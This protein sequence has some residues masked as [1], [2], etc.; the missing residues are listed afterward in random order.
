MPIQASNVTHNNNGHFYRI[1]I[2]IAKEGAEV[3]DLTPYFKGRV[4]DDNFGLQI[5]WYY[6]GRLLDVTG[7]TPYIKGN[8]G[9]YSFDDQKNLQLAPDA[10]VVVSHGNPNDCQANGQATYYFPQQMFMTD[11]VFKGFIGLQDDNQNLTGVDIWFRVLPGVAKMGHACDVYVDVLDK[12]IADFKEKIRQQSIDF[13]AALQQELQKEKALIQQKLDAAD[14]AMDED[15]AALKKLAAAVGA[16]QVQIDAGNV[17]S[18]QEFDMKVSQLSFDQQNVGQQIKDQLSKIKVQTKVF[19]TLDDLKAAYPQGADGL[20]MIMKEKHWY[21][22]NGTAWVDGGP[23]SGTKFDFSSVSGGYYNL[24]EGT[25]DQVKAFSGHQWE[26]NTTSTNGAAG[27]TNLK[28]GQTYTYAANV[29]GQNGIVYLEAMQTDA[30]GNRVKQDTV[31]CSDSHRTVLQFVVQPSTSR[32]VVHFVFKNIPG[33]YNVNVAKETLL[34]GSIDRGWRK[35]LNDYSL[36]EAVQLI[37]NLSTDKMVDQLSDISNGVNLLRD[38]SATPQTFALNGWDMVSTASNAWQLDNL[39]AG[40]VYTYSAKIEGTG[41]DHPVAL[42][43]RS[44]DGKTYFRTEAITS[45]GTYSLTFTMPSNAGVMTTTV[46][47]FSEFNKPYNIQISEE[48]LQHGAYRTPYYGILSN[49]TLQG[50]ATALRHSNGIDYGSIE[51]LVPYFNLL[52]GTSNQQQTFIGKGWQRFS[53]ATNANT[54]HLTKGK[55]YTYVANVEPSKG[56]G[57]VQAFFYD[58][59]GNQITFQRSSYG[60]SKSRMSLTFTV[61][62]NAVTTQVACVFGESDADNNVMSVDSEALFEGE[63]ALSYCKAIEECTQGEILQRLTVANKISQSDIQKSMPYFN[64]LNNTSSV[65]QRFTSQT[66]WTQFTTAS[67]NTLA[68]IPNNEYT[69]R[70]KLNVTKGTASLQAFFYD[71]SGDQ[72]SFVKNDYIS[73]S[74]ERGLTFTVPTNA[75]ST[76]VVVVCGSGSKDGYDFTVSK[77]ALFVGDNLYDYCKSI[78][79]CSEGEIV[80]QIAKYDTKNVSGINDKYPYFNLLQGTSTKEQTFIGAGWSY[81]STASNSTLPLRPKA[82]Y[83]Y[84]ADIEATKGT[85]SVQA[86][87]YD[88]DGNRLSY[89]KS[90]YMTGPTRMSVTFVVPADAT[91]TQVAC[92]FGEGQEKD[93]TMKVKNESLYRYNHDLGWNPSALAMSNAEILDTILSHTQISSSNNTGSISKLPILTVDG[94]SSGLLSSNEKSTLPFTLS[95]DGNTMS[96]YVSMEWQGDSSKDLPKHGFKTKFFK[97]EQ[98]D[99]KLKFKPTPTFYK[100]SSFHLKGYYTNYY[101]INDA[102]CAE[103]YSRFIATDELAPVQLQ[104]ANHYGTI[105]SM[106]VMLYFGNQFYGLMELNTKSGSDLWNMDKNDPNQIA[107]E[108]NTNDDF[109]QF[110]KIGGEL[111][112]DSNFEVQSDNETNAQVALDKLQKALV[113]TD[114]ATFKQNVANMFDENSIADAIIFNYIVN[115]SDGWNGKNQCYL[116]YD[117]GDHWYWMAYDFDSSLGSSWKPGTIYADDRDYFTDPDQF[118]NQAL[119][120]WLN[121]NPDKLLNRF[122]ELEAYG[123]LNIADLQSILRTKINAIGEIALEQEHDRWSGNPVYQTDELN[124]DHLC[125]MIAYRKRL[126]KQKIEAMQKK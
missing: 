102:A 83:T 41:G 117:G 88:K 105:Q 38:T 17:V 73:G 85:A 96:G 61:P 86:V 109:G 91:T 23:F 56:T 43:A 21:Y 76:K 30:N 53:T 12:T 26:A 66:D 123:V 37:A 42:K 108:V 11:G 49:Y 48:Q 5:V 18:K 119:R 82:T 98:E 51:T 54:L 15:T 50:I 19:S 111:K 95:R 63:N 8:V 112:K 118:H 116:T 45:D 39:Q 3:W 107:L 124:I 84:A 90:S 52:R 114:D 75:S 71:D 46:G 29:T 68:L 87:F 13:D 97:N 89:Q 115:N 72:I 125:Y 80:Q 126:L 100:S 59:D 25:S 103:I 16:I 47:A 94:D 34:A 92:V 120:R 44:L 65:E 122:N 60:T 101:G 2:D 7:K 93:Y 20:Y 27:L 32:T 110:V 106:P 121:L 36:P 67:N 64:L 22:W 81:H 58:N 74:F 31:D 33:T 79:E 77:E 4:G 35:S 1:A 57:S 78:D 6:Q 55:K 28:A 69:Y 113:V 99:K 62:D 9:H 14:D 40:Q 10:D 24:L 70:A 104:Q